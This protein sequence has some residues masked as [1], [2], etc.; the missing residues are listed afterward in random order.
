MLA[1]DL[2]EPLEEAEIR[3][4]EAGI[5]NYRLEDHPG[6]GVRVF[7]KQSLNCF[8]VVIRSREGVGGGAARHPRG[9][10]KAKGGNSGASLDQ[11]HVGVA[12][13]TALKFDDLLHDIYLCR[14][15]SHRQCTEVGI[16]SGLKGRNYAP[17]SM[18][19]C[20]TET[21]TL[22]KPRMRS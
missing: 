15:W 7:G 14:M 18:N 13:I 19:T 5:A 1:G 2:S 11:E 3:W 9:V 22:K 12:V 21:E 4:N 8:E 10:R 6:D 17:K 20:K 16:A